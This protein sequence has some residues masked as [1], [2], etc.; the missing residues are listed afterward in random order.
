MAKA[1][2]T[3]SMKR[4][5]PYITRH[6]MAHITAHRDA[7]AFL[8]EPSCLVGAVTSSRVK[9]QLS[10]KD[11]RGWAVGT[12]P[13]AQDGDDEVFPPTVVATCAA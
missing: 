13:V 6:G 2:L 8:K 12:M 3:N 1:R 5:C 11:V 4:F 10:S 7:S 9:S